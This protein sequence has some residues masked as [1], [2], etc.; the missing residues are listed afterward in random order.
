MRLSTLLMTQTKT[1]GINQYNLA[2]QSQSE[3]FNARK[4]FLSPADNPAGHRE[5]MRLKQAQSL[6][7]QYTL[8]RDSAKE[9][10]QFQSNT[11]DSISSNIKNINETIISGMNQVGTSDEQR[12]TY[13][14]QLTNFKNQMLSQVNRQDNSGEYIFSGDK[15]NV[16]PYQ[17]VAGKLEYQGGEAKSQQIDQYHSTVVN[18]T[19][20]DILTSVGNDDVFTL[21][22]KAINALKV[23]TDNASQATRDAQRTAL[24]ESKNEL[25]KFNKNISLS[26][27]K[28]GLQLEE[29]DALNQRDKQITDITN[30]RIT[31]VQ[32]LDPLKGFQELMNIKTALLYAYSNYSLMKDVNILNY[33]K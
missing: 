4:N 33:V 29:V 16:V 31:E 18:V 32:F 5:L 23:P 9:A 22:D 12:N 7:S 1:S 13:A 2:Q 27:A 14:Q 8:I 6:R 15:S 28:I 3:K 11:M 25:D 17:L 26:M 30:E 20:K 10:M 21:L 24:D 19:G